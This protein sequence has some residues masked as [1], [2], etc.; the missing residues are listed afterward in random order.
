MLKNN[1]INQTLPELKFD[2]NR[3]RVKYCPCGKSNKDGKFVPFKNYDEKG[4]CHSCGKTF[5]PE[6][7]KNNLLNINKK[8]T[9]P[10]F[11]S[12]KEIDFIPYEIFKKLLTEGSNLYDDNHFIQWMGNPVRHDS[13]FDE[14]TIIN[15][16][17]TYLIGNSN[18]SKYKGWTIFPYIDINKKVRNIKAIDYDSDT[19]KR[20]RQPENKCRFIGKEILNNNSANL[21]LCFFGEHLLQG[22]SKPIKIF[23]SEATAMHTTPFYPDWVCL[24]TGGKYGCKWTE[25]DNI[26]VLQGRKVILY[27]DIDAHEDWM[28]KAKLLKANGIDVSVSMVIKNLASRYAIENG[29]EYN[30]LKEQK[31]D[32]RDFLKHQK[33]SDFT[34]KVEDGEVFNDEILP[35]S[36]EDESVIPYDVINLHKKEIRE[37]WTELIQSIEND[38]KKLIFPD[39]EIKINNFITIFDC[40]EFVESNLEYVKNNNG[41]RTFRPYLD[42]LIELEKFLE[43]NSLYQ[44]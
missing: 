5:L 27:P 32:L 22:N 19:G 3:N 9:K 30:K 37:D 6:I 8:F 4:Y 29:I 7:E 36:S 39:C 10:S 38:F 15:L 44:I 18:L 41:K 14:L 33:L 1:Y 21:E 40:K 34:I 28:E 2:R 17:K 20:I 23:E 31:Y 24:A 11:K 25:K 35:A 42:Q 43:N 26:K 12:R 16:I 13:K